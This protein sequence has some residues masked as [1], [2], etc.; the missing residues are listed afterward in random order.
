MGF[1]DEYNKLKKKRLGE[2]EEE[3]SKGSFMDEYDRLKEERLAQEDDTKNDI[4]P[5]LPGYGVIGT[6]GTLGAP[7]KEE[8]EK[9][10]WFSKGAL[11]DGYQAGDLTKMVLGTYGDI[12]ENIGAGAL[13][14]V[15]K[16]IDAG[17]YLAG[18]A[19]GLFGNDDFRD[20]MEAFIEKDLIKEEELAKGS[21][22][23]TR[24]LLGE[25]DDYSVLGEKS[26]AL[27]QSGGQLAGTVGLQMVGVPWWL[28]TG[29]TSFGGS[30]EGALN[31]GATY[32][33][34]GLSA[35]INTGA[36]LLTEKLF[37]GSGLGEKGLINLEPLTK[38]I[39]SKLFKSLADWGVDVAAEGVEEVVSEFAGNLSSA[40]Y[41]EEKVGDLLFN[42]E[43]I[44]SYI[45]SFI[46]GAVLGGGM[47]VG[48]LGDSIKTGRDYRTDL[49]DNEQ[50]VV[51]RVVSDRVAEAEKDGKK[52]TEKEADKI[53]EEVIEEMEK[54]YISTDTIEEVLGGDTYKSYR[55][56][57][58]SEEAL[59]KEYEE[60]VNL[61]KSDLTV[62]QDMRIQELQQKIG[63]FT[64]ANTRTNLKNQLGQ[65]VSE[66]A[67]SDRLGESYNERARRGQA[68][69]VDLT[70]YKPKQQA[71]IQKAIDSGVLNNTRRTHEFVDMV[72]K[73]SA[74]KGVLFDFT[75]NAK[76][77]ES[78]FAVDGKTVNGY[79]TKDG[80]TLNIN[81]SKSLDKV[82]GH[83]ITHVLEGTELYDAL[84]QTLF[85][86]A[87]SKGDY[88]GRLSSLTA[89]Y[90][91]VE[92][93]DV[94]AELTA[95]LVGDYLFTDTDFIRNLSTKHQNIFQKV[96]DE[97]KYLCKVATAGS[98]EARQLERVRHAFEDAYRE[99]GEAQGDTKYSLSDS[100]G[101]QLTK[102]QQEYFRDSKVR[103]ENGNLKVMYHGTPNGD[104]SVFRDG[105]YFTDNKEYADRYQ[106]PGASS[107]SYG[108]VASNPKTFEV[109]LDIKKPFDI[110]NDEEARYIY[111]EE[112]IKGGNAM[113]INPYLSDAEYDQIETVDWTEGE[114]LRDFLIDNEYDY[115]GL[116]LDEGADGGYGDDVVYRGKSYVVFS[117]EQVKNV[118]NLN[119]TSDSDIR[120]SLSDAGEAEQSGRFLGKDLML[121]KQAEAPLPDVAPTPAQQAV[122]AAPADAVPTGNAPPIREI[123]TDSI[124]PTQAQMLNIMTSNIISEARK[125]NV[126]T[127]QFYS[128]TKDIDAFNPTGA[129]AQRIADALEPIVRQLGNE[130]FYGYIKKIRSFSGSVSE[131]NL[132][133]DD[134]APM[135]A[136]E[137]AAFQQDRLESLDEFDAPP[138][139]E[140]PEM[141]APYDEDYAVPDDP[142]EDR[143]IKA[144]GNRKVKS[145]MYENPEVKPF[146]QAAASGMLGDLTN[147]IK[148]EKY[149]N[150]KLYYES[151]GEYGWSGVKRQTTDDIAYLLDECGYTYAQIENGLN[152]IIEDNGAENNA[153]SKRIEFMLNDRLL[154]GYTGVFGEE[155]PP[156][157]D[158]INLLN[159]KQ[160]KEYSEDSLQYFMEHADEYMPPEP[161]PADIGPVNA[162]AN[163]TA[164]DVAPTFEAKTGEYGEVEG[165]QTMTEEAAGKTAKI[166]TEEP[167]VEKKKSNAWAMF[168][169]NVLDKG[170]VFE[171]LS[172]K[173]GNRELQARWNSIR[174]AEGKAQK[175]IGEGNAEVQSL[176]S[177]RDAVEKTGKTKEFY[178]YLYHLHNVDR[179]TLEERYENSLKTPN[180]P[181][182]GYNV[183]A[184][185]SREAATQLEKANPEFKKHAQDVYNYMTYLRRLMVDNGVISIDTARLWAEMYPHYVP[186]RRVGDTGLNINVPL[187]SNK[188]GVNAPI[189]KATGGNRDILP[190]FDT[191][192]QR[193]IQTYKAIA[194]NRFGVELKNTIGTEISREVSGVDDAIDSIDAQDGLLQA[195][196]NGSSPTFTVFEKGKR[197]TF[198]I[199]DEMYNAMK[200]TSEG[201]AYTNNALNNASSIFRGLTTEYNPAF[202]LTN[203]IKD[204][205][206]V[207]INSQHP[208]Q[209]YKN[210]PKAIKELWGKR[211]HWYQEYMENGGDQ[212]SYFDKETNTFTADDTGI[213]K[214]I[215]IPLNKMSEINNFIERIPRMAEYIASREAGRSVDVSMLDA[216]RV[217]TNFAAG[218]DVTK[219]LNRNGATFLNASVQGFNQNVRNIRE[220]KANGLKGWIG[221]A[222][223]IAAAGLPA[224]ILNHLM[225]DDDEEY[226]E[227]SDYVKQNYY[228]VAKYG[229]GKFVRIPKGRTFAVIQNAFEQMGNLITGN[230]E[231]DMNTFLELAI[232]NLA[233]NN[234]L[235]NNIFAPIVQV[236][237][238]KTWYGEDLVP[239]RLQ[240]LPAAEQY[241]E[242]TD[243]ISK[244][245]GENMDV[246]PYMD[247]SPYKINYLLNQYSGGIGDMILP[248]L[249]PEAESGG[250]PVLGAFTAPIRDK[251]TTDGVMNNQNV[252]DFYDTKDKVTVNA[253]GSGAT[254]EDVLM[255][256]YMNSIN[257]ELA[258]LYAQKREIQNDKYLSNAEKY[259]QVKDIQSQIVALT[260]DSLNT[261]DDV[262]ISGD[263]ATIG[264]RAFHRN[265][266]GEW[267]K[268]SDDQY[269]K[270]EEVTS[271]LGISPEAYWSNKDE[272]DFEYKYPEKYSFFKQNGIS[273]SDYKSADEDGKRAYTWA[274]ENP[275]K[276]TMSKA[277][278][279]D[280]MV[281]YQHRSALYDLKADKDANG[282]TISGS[283][284]EKVIDYINNS[285]LDYGQRIILYRSMYSSKQDKADYNN[286]I[287]DYL[288]SRDDISY[289]DMV[290]ILEELDMVVDDEGYITW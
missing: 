290:T 49:T 10:T 22:Y 280:F 98:K 192:G 209:T 248:M 177:I 108:K 243:A 44:D 105:T 101:K 119:P 257:S 200:P 233:P 69:E 116:V 206:D 146:F 19:A 32:G 171:D 193:T 2:S 30:A 114:D 28:T 170:M 246:I 142:F 158:Y 279:D 210:F 133:P 89:L 97:I 174:Y 132:F 50:K 160:I 99:S 122:P 269:E 220:A 245:L 216:A 266:D 115:D 131:T 275:G 283:K 176:N 256:K 92:G 189:K 191:I 218:G 126:L 253:N 125:N 34:A 52:L 86:Y 61:K 134:Y 186:I 138:E 67:M 240:N 96:W 284:K 72:A 58:D 26:D 198:E 155:V 173:T 262:K 281:Y 18:G 165:Q 137:E 178:E 1:M 43:A 74:D 167:Q 120:F 184:A 6:V 239:T 48:K 73:I 260:R 163:P 157:P 168:K 83:E 3:T 15:E 75:D 109:Y 230:D 27:L 79:V 113:G 143:D 111:I 166:L 57:V 46:G 164:G 188:T 202:A 179:M 139:E 272:Y 213:K 123:A 183:T 225:W 224:L 8:E 124:S 106:N 285:D 214:L 100:D 11:E 38:G 62:K 88:D 150:D 59:L 201:F 53:R 196:K 68:F 288:N 90:K 161:E 208:A 278:S 55:D 252:A 242:S 51:D 20:D 259:D 265:D 238:N 4:A 141:D 236:V 268:L 78:G 91:N 148:G 153:V 241:D 261:Y 219:F 29:V 85:D 211:G 244:W 267:V 24:K 228:V 110:A 12:K 190:L 172:L 80:V 264:D 87:K 277:I 23:I 229:D 39:S 82:V 147:T 258:E 187:D 16:T 104:F 251:F 129:D 204:A 60:L 154:K 42:E 231:A 77:K 40:L 130:N 207:L 31:E 121:N 65:E 21:N 227:L 175:L 222:T 7:T 195:G 151:G 254:E 212:N 156:D 271:S 232:S 14:I 135:S 217:T 84:Q 81:A 282:D 41:K 118:D 117:P 144:V 215:G 274:Y 56:T 185:A 247:V 63:E 199:T 180:K 93:A 64:E 17:A 136:E 205:Q 162:P 289:E 145:Y 197:V 203:P 276:Y 194:K 9:R 169:N 249:T 36:E 273:Y 286:D 237:N 107:I 70:K 54:G 181:V 76:L 13:G 152:A 159:E 182:F 221:L 102:E 94:N 71:V 95:D 112:Y 37:G 140:V 5:V 128:A 270:Q 149:Y 127:E 263:Y 45:E 25:L 255:N 33:Q 35:A 234:P 47:N 66:L 226:A 235:E 103:D 223:K 287:I 250:N